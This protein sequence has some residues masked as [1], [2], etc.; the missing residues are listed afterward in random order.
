MIV[1]VEGNIGSGKSTVLQTLRDT[2]GYTVKEEPI[3]E[4]ADLLDLYYDCPSKW[5]LAFNLKVLHSFRSIPE[6]PQGAPHQVVCVERSP[7]ACRHVFGQLGYN[8]EHMTPAA[9]DIFKEYHDLLTWEPDAYV[10]INTSPDRCFERI[11]TRGRECE[12]SLDREYLRRIEFQY[13]NYLKFTS[14]PVHTVN[15]DQDMDKVL[16]DVLQILHHL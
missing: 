9:W 10:Y 6:P 4:W 11:H 5:A 14:K 3:D 7:G 15:G 13:T 2:H 16:A 1:C 12:D 8:D